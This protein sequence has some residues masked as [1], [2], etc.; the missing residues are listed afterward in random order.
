MMP[1]SPYQNSQYRQQDVMNATPL[2]LVVMAY[3]VAIRA[4]EAK[5]FEKAVKT[6]SLLRDALDFDYPDVSMGLFRLYEWCMECIRHGDYTSAINTLS[7]LRMAW[8]K[9]ELSLSPAPLQPSAMPQQRAA[10]V[11]AAA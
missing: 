1:K 9:A 10:Q 2:H 7:E 11:S 6:I 4:C 8:R 5:D 3:D